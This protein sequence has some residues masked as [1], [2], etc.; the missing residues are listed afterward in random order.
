M[1]LRAV[2]ARPVVGASLAADVVV[3]VPRL[4]LRAVGAHAEAARAEEDAARELPESAVGRGGGAVVGDA[5]SRLLD[6]LAGDARV[7]DGDRYPLLARVLPEPP[8]LRVVLVVA[9]DPLAV[10][11]PYRVREGR[12]EGRQHVPREQALLGEPAHLLLGAGE[13]GVVEDH[14]PENGAR[15]EAPAPGGGRAVLLQRVLDAVETGA[16]GD[17]REDPSHHR[18]LALGDDEVGVVG[19]EPE[20]VGGHPCY[21]PARAGTLQPPPAGLPRD[22]PPL[23]LGEEVHD[24]VGYAVVEVVQ[25]HEPDAVPG[26]VA[27]EPTPKVEVAK[28]P[29][30]PSCAS[31]RTRPR[32]GR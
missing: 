3:R 19:V 27:L 32:P 14:L 21:D 26:E 20:A 30:A 12:V 23:L 8:A 29:I 9:L 17:H 15:P 4:A 16:T 24:A 6:V 2:L 13:V 11:P 1:V 10:E 31:S 28:E 18:H 25:R 5:A 22:L 7:R